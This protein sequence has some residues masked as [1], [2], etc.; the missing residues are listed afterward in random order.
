MLDAQDLSRETTFNENELVRMAS[1]LLSSTE[2]SAA[3]HLCMLLWMVS[4][5]GR[6]DD[7]RERRV[8]ELLPPMLRKCI[9][10]WLGWAETALLSQHAVKNTTTE[11]PVPA[12]IPA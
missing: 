5:A 10:G 12:A 7:L 3:N 8:C 4:T 2:P 11:H 6:G 1:Y 9:G